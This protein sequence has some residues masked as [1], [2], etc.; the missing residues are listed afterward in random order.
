MALI[1]LKSHGLE[2]WLGVKDLNENTARVSACS[3]YLNAIETGF[4]PK[5]QYQENKES[6][7]VDKCYVLRDL[8]QV[9]GWYQNGV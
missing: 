3:D 8:Q 1:S 4:L 6:F 5:T 9:R 2:P 7:W